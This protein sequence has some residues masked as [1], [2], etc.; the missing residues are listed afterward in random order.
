M[1]EPFSLLRG[2]RAAMLAR[3]FLPDFAPQVQAE[4]S[5]VLAAPAAGSPGEDLRGLLWSSID[6]DDSLDLDQIEVAMDMGDGSVGVKVAIADVDGRVAKDGAIDAH[7]AHNTTSV[8]PGV[9]V[10]TMLPPPLSYEATSLKQQVDR[11]AI[12]ISFR[13]HPD[14]TLDEEEVGRAL[15]RNKAKLA[16]SGLAEWL[17]G[18]A[19]V[20]ARVLEVQGLQ[21]QLELQNRATL[22]LRARRVKQGALDLDTLEARPVLA[23]GEV[24]DL[25]LL[26]DSRSRQLIED[27]MVASNGVMARFLAAQRRSSLAR[28]VRVPKRW[29]R[30][31]E[32]A[33]GLGTALPSQ[34]DPAVLE[35]FLLKQRAADPLRFPDLSLAVV[36]LLG[37]G[38]Y[39][40]QRAGAPPSGHFGLAVQDYTHS[41]APNRRFADLVTQRLVKAALDASPAPYS[42]AEL[43][44][45]ATRCTL[46]EDGARHVERLVRKM[47]AAQLLSRR[48]GQVF[49]A[50]VTGVTDHG[51]FA[52][53]LLPPA[54]GRVVRGEGGL[55]VGD[56][57]RL[58]L[59]ATNLERGFIDFAR[60]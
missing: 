36:K 40:L 22:A 35:R 10:F 5:Q 32:L 18:G 30:I 11:P 34:P 27:L 43:Q 20:P 48:V 59:L 4:L 9:T 2:A 46:M 39:D 16:Y 19:G 60:A 25:E 1:S 6:N 12:V 17:S 52:R 28:V 26:P 41:T 31:V 42:D 56:R 7:A 55:D 13:V 33:K 3:G 23:D 54:E 51:T 49:D 53:L 24:V 47:A 44:T 57:V 45:V 38:E 15:V 21:A 37:P 50:I 58:R 8:Y 29:E 14:G